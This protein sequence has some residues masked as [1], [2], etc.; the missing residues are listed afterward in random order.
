MIRSLVRSEDSLGARR[1]PQLQPRCNASGVPRLVFDRGEDESL[2]CS[3][4]TTR[5]HVEAGI[6]PLP[7]QVRVVV[8]IVVDDMPPPLPEK[9]DL[10]GMGDHGFRYR[11]MMIETGIRCVDHFVACFARP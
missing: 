5:L 2:S 8:R 3:G 10:M 9:S 1:R 4:C 7:G 6:L 11:L